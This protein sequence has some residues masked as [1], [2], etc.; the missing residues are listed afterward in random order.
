MFDRALETLAPEAL[1]DRQWQRVQALAR[2]VVGV[3]P[4]QTAKWRA[5]GLGSADD[6]RGW[7][8]FSRLPLTSKRELVADQAE[9]AL[10]GLRAR[11]RRRAP[12]RSCVLSV[13]IWSLRGLLGRLRG[14]ARARCAGDS[15]RR[16]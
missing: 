3:N 1:R 12:R 13:L 11:R 5:A 9:H 8:D 7:D 15:R 16:P 10:L 4:F 2:A 14:C 6:L